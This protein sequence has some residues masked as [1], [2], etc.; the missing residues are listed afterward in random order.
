MAKYYSTQRPITPGSFPKP[1]GNV[2]DNIVNFNQRTMVDSIGREAWGYV[3]Y[4]DPLTKG[5]Y[6]S[7]ELT[8]ETGV[9]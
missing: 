7:Y 5:D 1:Q 2:V 9:E 3:E 6:L 8:P 4:R